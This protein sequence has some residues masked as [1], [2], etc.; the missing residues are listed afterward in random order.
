PQGRAQ[1]ASVRYDWKAGILSASGGVTLTKGDATLRAERIEADDKFQQATAMGNVV[2]TKENA[3]LR[4][5]QVT[6]RDKFQ[7][8]TASGGVVLTKGDATVRAARVDADNEQEKAIASGGVVL[9]KGN[10]TL[11]AGRAETFDRMTR[12]VAQ[13][14]VK[15]RRSDVTITAARAEATGIGTKGAVRIMATGGVKLVSDTGTTLRASSMRYDEK[16][17]KVYASGGVTAYEPKRGIRQ[18]S[19]T[20]E[21]KLVSGKLSEV[22]VTEGTITMKGG[23]FGK[24]L[25][26]F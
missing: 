21:A 18:Q 17:G 13:G 9:T 8:A 5:E 6:A 10:V 1:A 12:A 3:T 4:A 23:L 24:K 26:L 14:G 19:K 25:K 22:V 15:V 16:A 7:R 20:L 2:L 11:H